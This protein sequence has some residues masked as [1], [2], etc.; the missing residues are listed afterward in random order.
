MLHSRRLVKFT[1]IGIL[2]LC[3]TGSVVWAGGDRTV[4]TR[5]SLRKT[6]GREHRREGVHDGNNVLTI[7]F[8]YGDIGN[9]WGDSDRL[10][11]GIF[12]KGSGHS[13]FAEFT[14][15]IGAEVTDRYQIQRRIFSDGLGDVGRADMSPKGYQWGFEPMLGYFDL[16]QDFIAMSDCRDNDGKDGIPNSDDDDGKPDSWP[17]LWPD[18]PDWIDPRNSVP[19]WNGQYGAYARA[20][21]ESYYRMNDYYNDEFE[22]WPDPG[23]SS[24]RGLAVEVEARGYQWADPAAEDIIIFTYW[25]N[26]TGKTV[27]QRTV[28]GMYGDA[29][30]GESVDNS[31]DLSE[32]NKHDDI[33]Y[34][35]DPDGWSTADGGFKPAYFGWK[36]LESP[37]NP[38]DGVDND[39]DGMI[40]ESQSDGIDNDGDWDPLID[41]VGSDGIGSSLPE[42]FGPD[43][44]G[45]EGNGLPDAGEPNFEY[46][47]N[48]ESDQ[49]GLT[50]FAS[51]DWKLGTIDL[52]NDNQLWSQTVPGNFMTAVN[53]VDIV[54]HYGSAYF[55][56]PPHPDSLSRRK[57]A[58]SMVMG[59][60]KGDLLR[61]AKTMQMIYDRDYNFARPPL[62]PNA[63]AVSG[64]QKVTLYWDKFAERSRD[65]IYG[66]DFE[67]YV[68]YR[69]TDPGFLENN[70]VTDT[71]GN[72]AFN[73]PVAQFD[74]ADSL[75]GPHPIGL[76]GVQFNMGEDSGLKYVFVDSGQTW[77]GPI[78]NGQVYYYAVCSYDKGYDIDFYE[79][80]LSDI[81]NLLPHAPAICSKRIQ[82]DANGVVTFLDVNTVEVV[83]NAPAAGYFEPPN[84]EAENQTIKHILGSGTGNVI[85]EPLDPLKIKPDGHYQ[86]IFDDSTHNTPADTT[87][88]VKD[89]KVYTDTVAVDTNFVLLAHHNLVPSSVSIKLLTNPDQQFVKNVDYEV[90]FEMGNIR[91]LPD[92]NLPRQDSTQVHKMAVSYQYFPIVDSPYLKGEDFN[93][94]FDGL[95]LFVY[96]APLDVSSEKSNWLSGD[97]LQ[98]YMANYG[99]IGG[100]DPIPVQNR[101]ASNYHFEVQRYPGNGVKVP[102]D[103]HI[104]FY[105]SITG[106]TANN[107]VSTVRVFNLTTNDTSEFAFFDVNRDSLVNDQDVISPITL[108]NNRKTPTW[109]VKFWKPNNIIIWRDSLDA[110]GEPV[111]KDNDTLRIPVD[112]I[113]VKPVAPKPGD[114]FHMFVNKPF[115]HLDVFEFQTQQYQ[116]YLARNE[117]EN[118]SSLNNVAVVPNP[119]VVTASWEPKHFYSS[120]RGIRKIDFIHLP[121]RCT[122]KI[123]TLRGYL[124]NSIEH[125]SAVTDGAESW[126]LLSK[127]GMEIAYGVYFFH[128]STPSGENKI[129]KFAVIK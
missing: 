104:V 77:A 118:R 29:D 43:K 40:D 71:Y 128:V 97:S 37:G 4:K 123:F 44:D 6:M 72:P 127:D 51:V 25:V 110:F 36:F 113:F 60:D 2:F 99:F 103:F 28:F 95:R 23:D 90:G 26:N 56:L 88:Y 93:D 32:F 45:T 15:F 24:K 87:L 76:D 85:V 19:L 49:I 124:V 80:G 63:Y 22:F 91:A 92:G 106:K 111:T 30:I 119:Y 47:D 20:D 21:Q 58:I 3:L 59:M 48:D 27:Y 41:D 79:K 98:R 105:D 83:P 46:T 69:A 82:F 10:Q 121:P 107:K 126:N 101:T 67:G 89:M 129:G 81:E 18:R 39:E 122:I 54:M 96:D 61:N 112:T 7:F 75:L 13:Y 109:Q 1:L 9:W 34:Q 57:F 120:G 66:Y 11:S 115:S 86:I 68:I 102:Y 117:V 12:P 17:W 78:E 35:W 108:V 8:N 100:D 116:Y 33:V 65:P 31:D 55:S 70:V 94:F 84:L 114:I 52:S 62:K 5:N 38:A 125:D 42:Y 50:S 64:N 53:R 73:K 16:D 14:P 74:I